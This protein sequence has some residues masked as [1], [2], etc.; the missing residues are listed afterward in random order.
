[1]SDLSKFQEAF[2]L[3]LRGHAGSACRAGFA[4]D[5]PG[6]AV[7]K[8]NFTK[9]S[10]DALVANYPTVERLVGAEWLGACADAFLQVSPPSSPILADYGVGFADFLESFEPAADMPYLGS[11]ARLD[12]LWFEAHAAADAEPMS[13][14]AL[15]RDGEGL[16][17]MRFWLH[18]SVRLAFFDHPATTIWRLNRPPADPSDDD[19][20][21]IVWRAEGLMLVRRGG[22]V[23]SRL[24]SAPDH[25][26]LSLCAAGQPLEGCATGALE[27]DPTFDVAALI[28]DLF[29][30]ETFAASPAT[31]PLTGDN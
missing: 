4:A 17:A 11:V 12:R 27:C 14:A 18:P 10:I 1:M 26:F 9:A 29:E 30:L 15:P 2:A 23:R 16:A 22:E 21:K 20:A 19:L 8:N 3:A 25:R 6:F 13:A 28:A 5:A 24:L 7:Y 31:S